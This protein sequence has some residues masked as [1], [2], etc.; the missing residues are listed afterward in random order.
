[1]PELLKPTD[2]DSPA[3]RDRIARTNR[4]RKIREQYEQLKEECSRHEAWKR[5]ADQHG[6]Q[7]STVRRIVYRQ[8]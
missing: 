4:N 7:P 5:L 8:R 6:L 1:M 2:R 3:D